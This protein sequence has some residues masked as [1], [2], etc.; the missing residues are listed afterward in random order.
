MKDIAGAAEISAIDWPT[1]GTVRELLTVKGRPFSVEFLGGAEFRISYGESRTILMRKSV[2]DALV[3]AHR[4]ELVP[5]TGPNSVHDYLS[6]EDFDTYFGRT[7][8]ASYVCPLLV[9][10]GYAEREG[11]QFRFV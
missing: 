3:A 11:S 5:L 10:L 1:A 9:E 8:L 7:R 4:G 2:L 6:N